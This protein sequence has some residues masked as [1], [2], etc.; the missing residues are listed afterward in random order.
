MHKPLYVGK[1]LCSPGDHTPWETSSAAGEAGSQARRTL[2]KQQQQLQQNFTK[3]HEIRGHMYE[4]VLQQPKSQKRNQ[5]LKLEESNLHY[6]DIQVNSL[7]QPR[8]A[9]EVK[10]WYLENATEYATLCF[11]QA[12]PRYD[13]KNGTLV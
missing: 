13:S 8:S 2:K 11:P 6:A 10:H 5:D 12:T 7:T 3:D 9:S 4:Q 1:Q